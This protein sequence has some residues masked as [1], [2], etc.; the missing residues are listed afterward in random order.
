MIFRCTAKLIKQLR[1]KDEDVCPD[2]G[3]NK[4]PLSSW[5]CN[6]FYIDRKKCVI[7]T[8]D[9]TLFT[10]IATG[11]NQ[12]DLR[13]YCN[14][15][16]KETSKV[17]QTIEGIPPDVFL[18]KVDNGTDSFRRTNSRSVLGS[19]NEF[20]FTCKYGAALEGGLDRIN[21]GLLSGYLN[22]TPM[23]AIKMSNPSTELRRLLG[24]DLS[25][26]RKKYGLGQIT[27]D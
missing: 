16:R 20:I 4:E 11:L 8:H 9:Q 22:Q 21:S 5:H 10:V 23:K 17:L 27:I 18:K 3:V 24:L 2:P 7:F 25:L 1:L 19:M 13:N 12:A 6:L 14:L 26:R 15:F